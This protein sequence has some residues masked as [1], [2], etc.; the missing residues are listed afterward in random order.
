MLKYVLLYNFFPQTNKQNKRL[1][2]NLIGI[3][4]FLLKLIHFNCICVLFYE[5]SWEDHHSDLLQARKTLKS[6]Q[7]K[8]AEQVELSYQQVSVI[9]L[10]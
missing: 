9:F 2:S 5:G 10:M 1:A 4:S 8:L 3:F 6:T 7:D